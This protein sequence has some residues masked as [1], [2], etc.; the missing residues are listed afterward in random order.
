MYYPMVAGLCTDLGAGLVYRVSG[1][2]V[3]SL[4]YAVCTTCRVVGLHRYSISTVICS[5]L[6]IAWNRSGVLQLNL[7]DCSDS[8]EP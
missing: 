6:I 5:L 4:V 8:S 7:P 2:S 3:Y 1:W